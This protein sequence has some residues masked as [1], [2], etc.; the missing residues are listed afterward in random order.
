LD[1]KDQNS[2]F[3]YKFEIRVDWYVCDHFV[4]LNNSKLGGNTKRGVAFSEC[5][6]FKQCT[7]V[8]FTIFQSGGFI[9]ATEVNPPDW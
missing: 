4:N 3:N 6:N 9:T 2:H 8:R 5:M 1:F 7:E